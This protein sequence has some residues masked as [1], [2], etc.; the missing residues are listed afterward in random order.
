MALR[1]ISGDEGLDKA[2]SKIPSN[3]GGTVEGIERR[4]SDEEDEGCSGYG[5]EKKRK[6]VPVSVHTSLFCQYMKG[7]TGSLYS[8]QGETGMHQWLNL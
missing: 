7:L 4:S 6:R 8:R 2:G 5:S 1:F 3:V